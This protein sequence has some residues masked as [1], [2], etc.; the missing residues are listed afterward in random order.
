MKSKRARPV[1]FQKKYG[2][3]NRTILSGLQKALFP[4]TARVLLTVEKQQESIGSACNKW[5]IAKQEAKML[6]T[7]S[8][9]A[10]SHY[11]YVIVR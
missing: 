6:Q 10:L 9:P 5:P 3:S 8:A 4:R 1:R 2:H 7:R 11:L